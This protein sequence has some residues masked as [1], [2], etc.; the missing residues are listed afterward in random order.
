MPGW[1]DK[2][3]IAEWIPQDPNQPSHPVITGIN[4]Y[5][6]ECLKN[7]LISKILQLAGDR[8]ES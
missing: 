4:R 6:K 2:P 1:V 3:S 7:Y 8:L 5:I